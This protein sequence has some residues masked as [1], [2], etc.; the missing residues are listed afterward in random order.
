MLRESGEDPVTISSLR[1]GSLGARG[2]RIS[3]LASVGSRESHP[4]CGDG[5]SFYNIIWA[6]ESREGKC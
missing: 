2:C 3:M 6:E 1:N 4:L 5:G